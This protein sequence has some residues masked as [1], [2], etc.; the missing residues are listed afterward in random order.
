MNNPSKRFSSLAALSAAVLLA[1][2]AYPPAGSSY[3]AGYPSAGAAGSAAYAQYGRVT[4]VEYLR[5][6]AS[7]SGVAGTVV[8]GAVGGLAGH[9]VGGGRGRTAATIVGAV[10]GALIGNAIERNM[11]GSGRDVYRV[12]VQLD[13]G[14]VRSFDYAQAPNVQ[15]GDS[16]RVDGNQLYR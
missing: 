15:I 2:C 3:P 4:N 7:G 11:A 16:V 8:G 12:T 13:N 10:G 5:G 9:Q 6:N 1:G 14:A